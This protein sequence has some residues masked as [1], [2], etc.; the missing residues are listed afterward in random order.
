[1][2]L[3]IACQ[4]MDHT[5]SIDQKIHE[6]SQRLQ[7][8][9]EGKVTVAWNCSVKDG[10]H[11]SE[12]NLVGPQFDYHAKAKA[13]NLYKTF[14]MAVAKLEKQIQRKKEKVKNKLHRKR[15]E[16]TIL[17]PELA[18]SEHVEQYDDVV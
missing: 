3:T 9:F 15:A 17:D 7:K 1:M 5:D 16:L 4:N 10:V 8:Y 13:D 12:V 18:W 2:K 11:Y 14:D 6:K